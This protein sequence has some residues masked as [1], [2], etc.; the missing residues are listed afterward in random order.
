MNRILLSLC[1]LCAATSF[2]GVKVVWDRVSAD[3]KSAEISMQCEGENARFEGAGEKKS[4]AIWDAKKQMLEVVRDDNKTYTALDPAQ[5]AAMAQRLAAMRAKLDQMPPEQRAQVEK[6]M[7]GKMADD[8][9]AEWVFTSKNKKSKIAKWDCDL[10]DAKRGA[11]EAEMCIVPWEKS[12]LKREDLKCVKPISEMFKGMSSDEA[13]GMT[14]ML[15]KFPGMPARSIRNLADGKKATTTLKSA[16]HATIAAS[17]FEVPAG[18]KETSMKH[19]PAAT[20]ADPKAAS[21]TVAPGSAPPAA[22]P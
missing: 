22:K 19:P 2:A 11:L 4:V 10:Y 13:D 17:A 5:I 9:K 21:A 6:M 16:D 8:P 20:A 12:P 1:V 7:G 14:D 15:E 3:G 18:Y